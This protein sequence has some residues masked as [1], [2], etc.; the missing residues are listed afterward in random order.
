MAG[1][2]TS[3]S[4]K[5]VNRAGRFLRDDLTDCE[6]DELVDAIAVDWRRSL[7]ALPLAKVNANLR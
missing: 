7:H 5:R 4:N 2:G 3:H 1:I 6:V